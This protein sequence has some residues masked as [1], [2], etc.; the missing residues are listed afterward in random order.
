MSRV[1]S[2]GRVHVQILNLVLV[3]GKKNL[4][5]GRPDLALDLVLFTRIYLSE[6]YNQ[7]PKN[8]LEKDRISG[9]TGWESTSADFHLF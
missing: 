6:V 4:R 9:D 1:Y 2:R 7:T 3:A 8:K 5:F